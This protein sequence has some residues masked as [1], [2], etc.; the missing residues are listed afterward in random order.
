MTSSTRFTAPWGKL[1]W[2]FTTIGVVVLGGVAGTTA[3]AAGP[4]HTWSLIIAGIAVVTL[5]ACLILAPRGYRLESDT[6]YIERLIGDKKVSLT[7]LTSVRHN[8]DLIDG[9][10]RVGN[11]GLFAFSGWYWSRQHGWFRLSGTDIL[12]RAVMLELDGVKWMITPGD[13]E[14]FVTE[15]SRLIES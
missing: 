4:L 5:V 15:A 11:G 14:L 6:L 8:K 7:G 10:L 9:A 1:L 2:L 3:I 13:P 12:G